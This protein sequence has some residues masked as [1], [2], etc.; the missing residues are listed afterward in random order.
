MTY[1]SIVH[2]QDA[3]VGRVAEVLDGIEAAAVAAGPFTAVD[4][5]VA[6]ATKAGVDLLSATLASAS[7]YWSPACKRF[8]VSIDYGITDPRALN[9]LARLSNAQVRVPN[10]RAVLANRRLSPPTTFHAK[11]YLFRTASW[12]SPSS[13]VVGSA[14]MTVS[15]LGPGSEVVTR[16]TWSDR[17]SARDKT[18]LRNMQGYLG[19]FEDA[20]AAADSLA[21]VLNDYKLRYRL[22]PTPR[23]PNEERTAAAKRFAAPPS[24]TVVAGPLAVQLGA[25]RALWVQTSTLYENR[26][27]GVPG[28]Q[29]D[30][31]RGT[32]VFFGFTQAD[33]DKNHRFGTIELQVP[34]HQAVERSVR[35]GNNSM[36]KVN[37]PI[38][39]RDGPTTYD[40]AFLIFERAGV[41][42]AGKD[43][44]KVIVTDA[45]GLAA[46]RRQA[47]NAVDVEMHHGGRGFGLFF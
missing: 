39:G 5:A 13:L 11:S 20:W 44:F 17:L 41:G 23:G 46:R 43:L 38:P 7:P 14:N 33:V 15:A 9:E 25:A 12:S 8:L 19:W 6:Y 36:D 29:L 34:G 28:N 31:P 3:S 47:R 42:P 18:Q 1:E 27:A 26:G 45:R 40:D 22:L 24:R 2:A 10:G 16:Q 35:F 32:R 4:A 21:D 30:T 37:L